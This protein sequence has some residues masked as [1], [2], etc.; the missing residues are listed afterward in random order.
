MH[1]LLLT[2]LACLAAAA[3]G[4]GDDGSAAPVGSPEAQVRATLSALAD[5][6]R[7]GDYDRY[8]DLLSSAS[9]RS[10]VQLAGAGGDCP[11]AMRSAMTPGHEAATTAALAA[12]V[13]VTGDRAVARIPD[14]GNGVALVREDGRWRVE[15]FGAQGLPAGATPA[16]P[17]A[18]PLGSRHD[19]AAKSDARAAVSSM[20][21]CFTAANTYVGCRPT[22]AGG[23]VEVLNATATGYEVVARTD[24]GAEYRI[25]REPTGMFQ[26]VCATPV[27]T[28]SCQDGTW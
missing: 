6:D 20:E 10:L 8:C 2:C 19:S 27:A 15:L 11:A 1:R 3:T 4:C 17:T 14:D 13:T 9:T 23:P 5:A 25:R 12:E 26:R 18:P 28:T 16:A 21:A 24:A 7:S 22:T